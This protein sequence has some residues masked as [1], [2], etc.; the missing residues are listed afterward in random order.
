MVDGRDLI[1]LLLCRTSEPPHDA[2]V[3]RVKDRTGRAT[4]AR[5]VASVIIGQSDPPIVM[6]WHCSDRHLG[7]GAGG[8]A[9]NARSPDTGRRSSATLPAR[10][11]V[12]AWKRIVTGRSIGWRYRRARNRIPD[13]RPSPRPGGPAKRADCANSPSRTTTQNLAGTGTCVRQETA[14]AP[15]RSRAKGA[16][17]GSGHH[18]R[19]QAAATS[20]RP[21]GD[22]DSHRLRDGADR[23]RRR[24]RARD[25]RWAAAVVPS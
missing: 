25:R 13:P 14:P 18:R 8:V 17:R 20:P 5:M 1:T 9:G 15:H 10:P 3:N 7:A 23:S 11:L 19:P 22:R 2:T 24:R 4:R 6:D 21:I 12:P 16:G